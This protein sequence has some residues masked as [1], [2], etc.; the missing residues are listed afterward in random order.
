SKYVMPAD[1]AWRTSRVASSPCTA[2]PSV[3]VPNPSSETTRPDAP[4]WRC[5]IFETPRSARR[6]QVWARARAV[7]KSGRLFASVQAHEFVPL[8]PDAF[9]DRA[10]QRGTDAPAIDGPHR[11]HAVA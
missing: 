6:L 8:G 1:I 2:S 5:S 3:V 9:L 10:R 4:S 11:Q 7:Q